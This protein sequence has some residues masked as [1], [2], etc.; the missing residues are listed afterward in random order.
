M[1]TW[2][3]AL[4]ESTRHHR[5]PTVADLAPPELDDVPRV[6]CHGDL[7]SGNVVVEDDFGFQVVDWSDVQ[8]SGLPLGDLLLFLSEALA[9][10]D[11]VNTEDG[12]DRYFV[13][14]MTG[15]SHSSTVLFG[16]VLAMADALG[17]DS[18]LVGLVAQT[19]FAAMAEHRLLLEGFGPCDPRRGTPPAMTD[20]V[21]R[22]ACLWT[23]TPGLGRNWYAWRH[24]A[25]KP[26]ARPRGMAASDGVAMLRRGVRRGER[27]LGHG[28]SRL[29]GFVSRDQ[30]EELE[31]ARVLV[32]APH[33]DDETLACGGV[34]ARHRGRDSAFVIVVSDG[35]RG[36]YGGEPAALA[37]QR[38]GELGAATAALGLEP[39]QVAWW[40]FEDGTLSS[41][42]DE[43]ADRLAQAIDD[44][45][46]TVVLS[47]WAYDVHP[48]HAALGRAARTA[49]ADRPVELLE[50]V[51]WAWD[52]PSALVR[53]N[54]RPGTTAI[55]GPSQWLQMGRPVAVATAPGLEA[56]RAALACYGSQLG[57]AG[58]ARNQAS[59]PPDLVELFLSR[60][61]L[62]WP[63]GRP[64]SPGV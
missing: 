54:R 18:D 14:L 32:L 62:F 13:E 22:R 17:L 63:V 21:V 36:V 55:L 8:A 37:A 44:L 9:E 1:A 35:S 6:L 26:R 57:S 39:A 46:P 5:E 56:K 31:R 2:L 49:A 45:C 33:P 10:L 34:L 52:R 27:R 30:S 51:V 19:A 59:V 47:P 61:E 25:G 28:A 40:G 43:L 15:Q 4:A 48:D 53:S 16:W 20:P 23:S 58:S 24:G 64:E 38:H 29:A 7:W 12:R 60:D 42:V 50:Y 11:G 3:L 41:H